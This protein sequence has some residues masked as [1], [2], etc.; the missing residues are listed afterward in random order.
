MKRV[1]D[2]VKNLGFTFSTRRL[3]RAIL[4]IV[5]FS[6]I[7]CG[8]HLF[9]KYQNSE[10]GLKKIY[11]KEVSQKYDLQGNKIIDIE[12]IDINNDRNQDYVFIIG[13]EIRSDGNSLNSIVELY[14]NVSLVVL[15]GESNEAKKYD[16]NKDF[17]SDIDLNVCEDKSQR[18][19]LV[20]DLSGNISLDVVDDSNN[21]IDIIKNTTDKEFLGYTIYI[22]KNSDNN[23]ILSISIDN[24]S[25]DYLGEYSNPVELNL[26]ENGID[27]SDYRETYLR[28]K[29]S[30]FVLKDTN[31]DGILELIGYQYI[32]YSLD[33][34]TTL[35]KTVGVIETIFNIEDNK[36]KF[37]SVHIHI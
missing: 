23:D 29:F 4:L 24:F 33:D 37:N 7:G 13:Q 22:N 3:R 19:F 5:L 30:K 9:Y 35:N 32:L 14:K 28:D 27:I 12:K 16:T 8:V 31:N 26:A 15:D 10:F 17:K 20:S 11:T 25:K 36:L 6:A 21:L 34:N 2:F 1:S 18:Y